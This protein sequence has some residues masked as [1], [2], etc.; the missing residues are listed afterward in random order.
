MDKKLLEKV[1][2]IRD[3][4]Q[5]GY[6]SC[7]EA[8]EKNDANIEKAIE[9]LKKQGI[10][11]NAI[12][13]K[14]TKEGIVKSI[15]NEKS[16][17]IFEVNCQTDFVAKND[18]FCKLIDDFA[19]KCLET[20]EIITFEQAKELFFSMFSLIISAI[21]EKIVFYRFE[22]IYKKESESFGFYNHMG[23]I[24]AIVILEKRDDVLAKEI[25]VHVASNNVRYLNFEDIDKK[26]IDKEREI[27]SENLKNDEKMNSKSKE[28]IDKI[29][30]AK[31][32]KNMSQFV[33]SEQNFL[34]DESHKVSYFLNNNRVISFFKYVLNEQTTI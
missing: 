34:Y 2:I 22:R 30:T 29:I 5:I 20:E 14:E 19:K 13:S 28:M 32:H 16:G 8:L 25:A 3:M 26:I 24:S 18:S 11:K 33:L 9:W 10:A 21:K 15:C 4:T 17:I 12:S 31:I 27:I 23:K 6:G 1:K 7:V